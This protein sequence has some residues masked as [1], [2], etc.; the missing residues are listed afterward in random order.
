MKIPN[1]IL[2]ASLLAV[3]ASAQELTWQQ[4]VQHPEM[5]PAQCHLKQGFDF[6][7]G[8]KVNAGDTVDVLEIHPKQVTVGTTT[9]KNFAF[10]V[11]PEDTDLL[12]AARVAYAK[13]TPKQRA[14]TYNQIFKDQTLWPYYLTLKD[15]L[16]LGRGRRVHKGDQVI[17]DGLK[18]RQLEVEIVTLGSGYDAEPQVT[19]FEVDPQETDLMAQARQF[20][21][22]PDHAPSRLVAQLQ[23]YLINA[24]TSEP[25]P[26]NTNALP[27]YFAFVRAANFCPMSQRFLPKLVKFCDEM[28]QKHFDFQVIYLS[29]DQSKPDMETFAKKVGFSW[30][31]VTYKQ[32]SCVYILRPHFQSLMP[33]FTVTDL[34]GN[35]LISG[36]GEAENGVVQ[37]TGSEGHGSKPVL[38]GISAAAALDQF[39]Q[40]LAKGS[41]N[42]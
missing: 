7:S 12:D 18:G 21:E 10:D 32:T 6:R 22:L 29:C 2:M 38:N 19:T 13:L 25:A 15:T 31:T 36:V 3:T 26:L 28:K 1:L 34:R 4:L 39:G 42:Q 23:P 5:W 30:P 20:V 17:F 37:A 24:A 41:A 9:G 16:D 8:A 35:V 11:K 27:R 33:Q 40:L 14:L